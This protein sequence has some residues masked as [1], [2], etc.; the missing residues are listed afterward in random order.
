MATLFF[1]INFC[2]V[3]S[4]LWM[5]SIEIFLDIQTYL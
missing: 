2:M 4:G 3:K 1:K 5:K